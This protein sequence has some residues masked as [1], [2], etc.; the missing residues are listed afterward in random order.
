MSDDAFWTE[1][2]ALPSSSTR[3][4]LYDLDAERATLGA[5]TLDVSVLADVLAILQ[6]GDFYDPRHATLLEALVAIDGKP[7]AAIGGH[8]NMVALKRHLHAVDRFHTVGG[9]QYVAE[10][11][12]CVPTAAHA[13]ESARLVAELA[14]RRRVQERALI[15]WKGAADLRR[16]IDAV[17]DESSNALLAAAKGGKAVSSLCP[18]GAALQRVTERIG[19][20]NPRGLTTPWP[21]ID[22]AIRGLRGG[23][24]HLV[25][26]K[27]SMGKSSFARNLATALAAPTTFYDAEDTRRNLAPIPTLYFA[28]EMPTDE[29]AAQVMASVLRCS[30]A[31]VE[32]GTFTRHGITM[33]DYCAARRV[34]DAAPLF[35]DAE[36]DS[37]ARQIA[38]ARQF[39]RRYKRTHGQVVV[40]VDYLQLANCDGLV[41]EKDPTRE[42]MVGAMSFAW[43]RFA[44]REDV[45]VIALSQLN[46][47]CGDDECPKLEHLRESGSLEQDSDVVMFLWGKLPEG[48]SI[49]Q[50]ITCTLAKI[51]GGP[52]GV[53]VPLTFHRAST[54]FHETEAAFDG[55]HN[56]VPMHRP[57]AP[58]AVDPWPEVA[59]ENE[60]E[61]GE[62]V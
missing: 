26:A 42:R 56:V 38:I 8:V 58:R 43:K 53:A 36:T 12:D 7:D 35:F 40:I 59:P 48:G 14:A 1:N 24:F 37:T 46:R 52:R 39:A 17:A 44:M 22:D 6:P 34:L 60:Q 41:T 61:L 15:A 19:T 16:P 10:L 33:D 27:T 23:R 18:V 3:P 45:P 50:S 25:A 28:L 9:S 5:I 62:G 21:T 2:D 29:N 11:S 13:R 31:D 32:N 4:K 30:G 49:T 57:S 51:R 55:L 20:A 54:R 47:G